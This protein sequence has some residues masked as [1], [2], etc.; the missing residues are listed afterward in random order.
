MVVPHGTASEALEATE[1]PL[2]VTAVPPLSDTPPPPELRAMMQPV[3]WTF[4]SA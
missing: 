4:S 2:A 1:Q 3:V